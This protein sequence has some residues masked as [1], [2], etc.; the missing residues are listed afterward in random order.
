M[1]WWVYSILL[2]GPN[3]H[4][5]LNAFQSSDMPL[6]MQ[7]RDNLRLSHL[8]PGSVPPVCK[9]PR[10]RGKSPFGGIRTNQIGDM[11]TNGSAESSTAIPP[12]LQA[13]GAAACG[14]GPGSPGRPVLL[15][16]PHPSVRPL[17]HQQAPIQLQVIKPTQGPIS[18]SRRAGCLQSTVLLAANKPPSIACSAWLHQHGQPPVLPCRPSQTLTCNL[19]ITR[20]SSAGLSM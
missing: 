3:F 11:T 16:G 2:T 15:A 14:G 12:Q 13:E 8:Y 9:E 6:N 4:Y 19:Q 10:N 1:S 17:E 7:W 18:A 20:D 5:A